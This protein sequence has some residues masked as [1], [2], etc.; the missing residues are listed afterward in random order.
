[1]QDR[2]LR[3]SDLCRLRIRH[4][5]GGQNHDAAVGAPLHGHL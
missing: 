4:R 2:E 5:D 3:G 1:M